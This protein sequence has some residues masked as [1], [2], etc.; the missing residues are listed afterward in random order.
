[1]TDL[2]RLF[3]PFQSSDWCRVQRRENRQIRVEV[4]QFPQV[5]RMRKTLNHSENKESN[6]LT[7]TPQPQI[8]PHVFFIHSHM[9]VILVTFMILMNLS[10]SFSLSWAFS[11]WMMIERTLVDR[12]NYSWVHTWMSEWAWG[13]CRA[14]GCSYSLINTQKQTQSIKI[15]LQF[16]L[17]QKY[18]IEHCKQ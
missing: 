8:K 9:S 2:R 6:A 17:W 16:K 10:S 13:I 5:L 15:K 4:I 1:M 7:I 14:W 18:T 3:L 11:C 12:R